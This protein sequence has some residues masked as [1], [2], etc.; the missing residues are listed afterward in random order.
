M[1]IHTTE[2]TSEPISEQLQ[3]LRNYARRV[4]VDSEILS[5]G[6]EAHRDAVFEKITELGGSFRMTEREIVSLVLRGVFL[7]APP[8][9]CSRCRESFL[10]VE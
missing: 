1:D 8:C 10:D 9:W 4:I 2:H 3:V 5:T 6:E 7:N